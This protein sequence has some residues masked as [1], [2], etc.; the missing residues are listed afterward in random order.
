[1]YLHKRHSSF[2]CNA[3]DRNVCC[4]TYELHL[5]WTLNVLYPWSYSFLQDWLKIYI[6]VSENISFKVPLRKSCFVLPVSAVE[7]LRRT[8]ENDTCAESDFRRLLSRSSS[9][10]W[11]H[12]CAQ[13]K[14][15]FEEAA[16]QGWFVRGLSVWRPILVQYST[17]TS[18]MCEFEASNARE[19]GF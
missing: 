13:W 16:Q 18:V 19:E 2:H 15:N 8:V 7:C 4:A 5:W 9:E 17:Y 12:L 14:S 11:K 1:M 3:F 6:S 10:S